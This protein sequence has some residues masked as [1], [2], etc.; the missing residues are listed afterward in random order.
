MKIALLATVAAATLI[1]A[2]A[3]AQ[4]AVGSAGISYVNSDIEGFEADGAVIDGSVAGSVFGDWT[5][6]LDASLKYSDADNFMG[7]TTTAAAAHVSRVFNGVRVGGFAAF[8]SNEVYDISS[9]GAEAQKTF[10]RATL[11]GS[12][13]YSDFLGAKAWNVGADAAFY[14]MPALRLN[15]AANY[16]TIKDGIFGDTDIDSWTYAVGAEYRVAATPYSVFGRYENKSFDDLDIDV[17][18]F[19]IGVRYNFG[20]SLQDQDRAGANIGRATFAP[21]NILSYAN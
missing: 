17:D 19:K 18:T 10:D 15:A 8:Q 9:F 12:L 20:G 13:A 3:F 6:T 5:V 7:D 16:E 21:G 4:D 14:P 11:T 1:A 2:P